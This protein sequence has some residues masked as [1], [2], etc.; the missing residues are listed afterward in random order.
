MDEDQEFQLWLKRLNAGRLEWERTD[1]NPDSLMRGVLL[2]EAGRWL[3][4]RPEDL[5]QEEKGFIEAGLFVRSMREKEE[6][7]RQMELEA[8]QRRRLEAETE[9][10]DLEA[11]SATR[12]KRFVQVL[13]GSLAALLIAAGAATFQKIAADRARARSDSLTLANISKNEPSLDLRLLL[14]LHSAAQAH[15]PQAEEALY[16]AVQA[17]GSP[18]FPSAGQKFEVFRMAISHDGR[19]A[20]AA[21]ADDT[22]TL[23]KVQ[24]GTQITALKIDPGVAGVFFRPDG[25]LIVVT[26]QGSVRVI[27]SSGN[28]A[29]PDIA[30]SQ[31]EVKSVAGSA[32]GSMLA[33]GDV[34]GGVAVWS[35]P[36]GPMKSL[37]GY[38]VPVLALAFSP[39]DGRYLVTGDANGSAIGWDVK[40]REAVFHTDAKAAITAVAISPGARAAVTGDA[41]GMLRVWEVPSG[42][43][44]DSQRHADSKRIESVAFSADGHT[45]LSAG[46][47]G[48]LKFW[49]VQPGGK[50][51]E[52]LS[53]PCGVG[54][55]DGRL[56]CTAGVFLG[57]SS[58]AAAAGLN[59]EVRLYQTDFAKLFDE[60]RHL[61]NPQQIAPQDCKLLPTQTCTVPAAIGPVR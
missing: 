50:L 58:I 34:D 55:A 51:V 22:V 1:R 16:L 3:H 30:V 59:G 4:A 6:L 14:A 18:R 8:A 27:D 61:V 28:A 25:S 54:G 21:K 11:K 29:Q 7:E 17:S 43:P 49:N 52:R 9:R 38:T 37:P 36:A 2:D 46:V 56:H 48:R 24:D 44:L 45:L 53:S 41:L 13:A 42:R 40:S 5:N 47:D 32:D 39:G 12:L 15:T 60:A 31:K 33:V 19:F 35:F 57:D 23:W 26:A 10:A 20:A